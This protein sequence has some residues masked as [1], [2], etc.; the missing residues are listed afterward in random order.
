M[1]VQLDD[2]T[3]VPVRGL[4][5]VHT[6]EDLTGA[7]RSAVAAMRG[8][9]DGMLSGLRLMNAQRARDALMMAAVDSLV[10]Q[11]L[12][13]GLVAYDGSPEAT[14]LV[15]RGYLD[16]IAIDMRQRMESRRWLANPLTTGGHHARPHR[17]RP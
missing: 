16:P 4:R 5:D 11:A 13:D 7:S 17:L 1:E 15:K 3:W 14:Y 10:S 12:V 9:A 2:G 6:L 8:M